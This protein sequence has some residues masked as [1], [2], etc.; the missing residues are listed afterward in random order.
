MPAALAASCGTHADKPAVAT[1]RRCGLFLCD[2]CVVLIREDSFCV[3]CAARKDLPPSARSKLALGLALLSLVQGFPVVFAGSPLLIVAGPLLP[4]FA[5]ALSQ[6][7]RRRVQQ[8]AA[9]ERTRP[10][11]NAAFLASAFG[12]VLSLAWAVLFLLNASS[13]GRWH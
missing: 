5:F 12:F 13:T 9:S 6:L 3:A 10:W 1:C 4:G 8:G 11:A 2:N 7:E